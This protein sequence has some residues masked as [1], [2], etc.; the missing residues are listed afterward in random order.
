MKKYWQLFKMFLTRYLTYRARILIWV[1]TDSSQFILFPFLWIA[2]FANNPLPPGYTL[3]SLITY[4][5]IL[6]VVSSGFISHAARHIRDHI[7]SGDLSRRLVLPFPLFAYFAMAEISYKYISGIISALSL[8]LLYIFARDYFIFPSSVLQWL[9]FIASV[10]ITF[11]ISHLFQ[12]LIGLSTFWLEDINA[13]QTTEEIIATVFSGRLAPLVFF[14][15]PIQQAADY[16]PFKYLAYIPAQIF[17]G[18]ITANQWWSTFAP[19]LVWILGLS[20]VIHA[21]WRRGLRRHEGFGL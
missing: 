15:L 14:A 11:V 7:M 3:R 8:I 4:Y 6:A 2:I 20:L 17:V 12:Y 9:M 21:V 19:A 5:V 13:F 1:F 16:L 18:N 10:G